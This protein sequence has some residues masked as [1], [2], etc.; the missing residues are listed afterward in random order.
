[1]CALYNIAVYQSLLA[2]SQD[3]STDHGFQF[4]HQ[5]L[6]QSAGIFLELK[7]LLSSCIPSISGLEADVL[8]TQSTIVLAQAQELFVLKA[9]EE[10]SKSSYIALL[11]YACK[12]L[13]SQANWSMQNSILIR[14]DPDL[15]QKV[16]KKINFRILFN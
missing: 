2:D 5:L 11:A 15:V 4:A 10:I 6:E 16:K 9:I 12:E 13:F 1:M 8:R 7:N 14:Q 3:I